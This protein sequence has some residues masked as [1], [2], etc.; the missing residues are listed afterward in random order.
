MSAAV[1]STTQMSQTARPAVQAPAG[2]PPE[3]LLH[4]HSRHWH[5]PCIPG[6]GGSALLALALGASGC[7]LPIFLPPLGESENVVPVVQTA[8]PS[9]GS[10]L[11]LDRQTVIAFVGVTDGNDADEVGF[12][13]EV[14]DFGPQGNVQY[15]DSGPIRGST[16]YLEADEEMA[17]ETLRVRAIDSYGAQRTVEWPIVLPGEEL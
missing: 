16:L 17:G 15:W 10:P 11:V 14:T 12:I 3:H 9:P 13:W 5:A 6:A 2:P 4:R 1:P 8:D 7:A